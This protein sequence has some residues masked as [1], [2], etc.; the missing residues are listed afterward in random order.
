MVDGGVLTGVL[1]DGWVAGAEE[2]PGYAGRAAGT[3]PGIVD[4]G[5]GARVFWENPG[6][7]VD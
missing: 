5:R 6:R 3:L 7:V 4:D 2:G 1:V